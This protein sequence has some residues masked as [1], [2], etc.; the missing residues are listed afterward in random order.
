MTNDEQ[1]W[2]HPAVD[3]KVTAH[4]EP[5]CGQA[6][7]HV[8]GDLVSGTMRGERFILV[9]SMT[10]SSVTIVLFDKTLQRNVIEV[11]LD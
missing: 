3:A 1:P 2:Y 10:A 7:E 5:M 6:T 11:T 9:S 4:S 8:A